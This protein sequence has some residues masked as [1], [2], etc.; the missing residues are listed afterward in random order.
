M[1]RSL[2]LLIVIT[3]CLY[4][5]IEEIAGTKHH[6]SRFT[7]KIMPDMTL[8]E[9]VLGKVDPKAPIMETPDGKPI[10]AE[11][12]NKAIQEAGI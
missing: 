10:T 11:E 4:L 12:F 7:Q 2:L 5:V 6:I 8:G 3:G 9:L 1:E